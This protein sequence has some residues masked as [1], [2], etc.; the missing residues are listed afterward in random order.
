[1]EKQIYN[2]YSDKVRPKL[3]K[4]QT[5]VYEL[6]GPLREEY[7]IPNTDLIKINDE[8]VQIAAIRRIQPDGKPEFFNITFQARS[9]CRII[10]SGNSARDA[11]LYEFFE[12]C[13]FNKS[14]ENRDENAKAIFKRYDREE[15]SKTKRSDKKI[16][17]EAIRLAEDLSDD[18]VRKFFEARGENPATGIHTLRDRIEEFAEKKPEE[19]LKFSNNE[20]SQLLTELKIASGRGVIVYD[21][22]DWKWKFADG[23]EICKVKRS[24]N[25]DAYKDLVDKI[26]TKTGAK[27]LDTIRKGIED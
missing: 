9:N 8:P 4:G 20:D 5:V 21:K 13:N 26:E 3:K 24:A 27:I 18:E 1:M 22:E 19:F 25:V 16:Q 7:F 6:L 17:R 14:N 2:N 15:I 12:L 10:L 11:K 23:T